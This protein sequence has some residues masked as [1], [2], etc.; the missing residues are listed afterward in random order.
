MS[1]DNIDIESLRITPANPFLESA[2]A[3]GNHCFTSGDYATEIESEAAF[4]AMIE[5]TGVFKIYKQVDGKYLHPRLLA[6]DKVPR[7]DRI[8]CPE[9][10]LIDQGWKFG[11]IGVELKKSNIKIGPP[12]SQLLDYSRA[13]WEIKKGKGYWIML[14]YSFLW[15]AVKQH[16]PIASLLAQNRIGTCESRSE[17]TP[18]E[19][20]SGE[21]RILTFSKDMVPGIGQCNAG[22]KTGSR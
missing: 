4:D 3:W 17:Y 18:L 7:I 20:Y 14:V 12:I 15:P 5:K 13:I 21:S 16:G 19:F 8:L 1:M 22:W 2:P 6:E 11:P 9:Q 10:K